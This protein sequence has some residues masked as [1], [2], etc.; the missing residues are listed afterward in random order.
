MIPDNVALLQERFLERRKKKAQ[1]LIRKPP[2]FTI[3]QSV[4]KVQFDKYRQRGHSQKWSKEK[5]KIVKVRNTAPWTYFLS[6]HGKKQFYSQDLISADQEQPQDSEPL[7]LL[8]G[9]IQKKVVPTRFLKS[10]T[11]RAFEDIYLVTIPNENRRYMTRDQ[12]SN[13]ANG[14][15]LLERFLSK[16][17]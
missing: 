9:I 8:S 10:G 2:I 5:F 14:T 11:P 12:I 16:K 1:A 3:G 17:S 6:G 15:Q 13:Y 4:R 7:K